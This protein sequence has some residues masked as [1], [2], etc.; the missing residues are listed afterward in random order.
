MPTQ[1]ADDVSRMFA[2]VGRGDER[3][4]ERLF[5]VIYEELR[6]VAGRYLRRQPSD[7]TLQATALVHEAYLRLAGPQAGSWR[8]RDH[9]LAT[10]AV[11]MRQILVN[12]AKHKQCLKRGG[13]RA[14]LSIDIVEPHVAERAIDLVALDDALSTL[15][16]LDARQARIVELRF[17]GGLSVDQTARV[18]D[19]SLR[20]VHREWTTARLWLR[21]EIEKGQAS[22]A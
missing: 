22:D 9:F 17:F 13:G 8:D 20:T 10:A 15:A 19:V 12:H 11:A 16:G 1:R 18:M 7:H 21:A 6:A 5:P 3:A 14:G 2:A 4:V